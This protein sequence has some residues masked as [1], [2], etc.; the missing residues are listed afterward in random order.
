M[1]KI[2]FLCTL[3]FININVMRAENY[4]GK[5]SGKVT[6]KNSNSIEMVYV[7][8]IEN[9]KSVYTDS[10]GNYSFD[11]LARGI[12][13]LI[14]SRTGYI[15]KAETVKLDSDN[16]ILN[17]ILT[18]SLIETS[19]I[20][21][22]SSFEAQDVS[23]SVFS[24]STLNLR[25]L[26][27]ER[28]QTLSATISKFP[29]VNT[30]S[31]GI[32]IGKPVIRGLTSNSVIV[33]HDGVK[34]ESQQWGDEHAPEISLYDIDRIEILRGPAS[35]KYG[36]DGIGGV[37]NI[38]SSPLLYSEN[39]GKII[40]YG[41]IDLTNATVNNEYSGNLTYGM[42]YKN[43]GF[44]AHIGFRNSGNIYTPD[45]NLIVRTLTPGV[46]DTIHGGT[47][48]NSGTKEIEGGFNL[49]LNGSFGNIE[50]GFESFGRKIQMHDPDPIST[51]N[52][53]L[54][55]KQLELKG[56][57][58]F[59]RLLKLESVTS[60]QLHSRK[61][62]ESSEDLENNASN[63]YWYLRTFSTDLMLHNNLK[64]LFSGTIG[65]SVINMSNKSLGKEKL[66]PNYNSTSIGIYAL[67]KYNYKNL[68]ISGGL[69]Y[70]TKILN[71]KSTV[72]GA[73]VQGNSLRVINPDKL[74]FN[75][76]SGSF[77]VVYRPDYRI[78]IFTNIGRGWRAPS[79]YELYVDGEHEGTNRIEKGLKTLNPGGTASPESSLNIDFGIRLKLNSFNMEISLFNNI[80][81]NFIYP[82]PTGVIDSISNLEIYDI[83][84]DKSRFTGIEY[85]LQFQP[86]QFLL[87]S[88][89]GDY[90]FTR[91]EATDN[92]LP[93]TPPMKNIIE[94][95]FQKENLFSLQNPY[96]SVSCRITSSQYNVDPLETVT[97]GYT[98]F[99]A[100]AGFEIV[101]SKLIASI[102]ITGSNLFNVKY[103]DHLS[104]Y[105]AY[106]LNPGRNISL[107]LTV[108]FQI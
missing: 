23:Q 10:L 36:A 95:K 42:G 101:F 15:S 84:Q 96:I 68:T 30:I 92:P 108:P 98:L 41:T 99:N 16:V 60:Y 76:L 58:P 79:E 44:K 50:A 25:A 18:A 40:N 63:L 94:V 64:D 33:V 100:S 31:T 43:I 14:F 103:V 62:F 66:I 74:T 87:L 26:I 71:I 75:A 88:L 39:S 2:I 46:S 69:R 35:L 24:I 107:K 4:G 89:N 3:I 104:R 32:G 81:D 56:E 51:A 7:T 8:F 57:F 54:D 90:V 22:T 20:D 80:I 61:E 53:K 11:N 85:S 106:A 97:D 29:G 73:D 70:D 28:E 38:I 6:D 17:V 12:Y 49:G 91:N 102:D 47:L 52:Q 105:K 21:V 83:K 13:H 9:G 37:I 77:G 45:G 5:I 27:R 55:T 93:F 67:E 82:S 78:D 1:R 59:N 34:Q 48:S 86:L 19:A 65:L 72:M